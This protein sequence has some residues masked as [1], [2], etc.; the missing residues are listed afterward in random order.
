MLCP[1]AQAAFHLWSIREIY[2]DA[3]GSLQ[4]V[5]MVDNSGGQNFV[6]SQQISVANVGATQT[7]N[8]T[9]PSGNLPGSTLG[10]TLLL[11]TAGLAAAG[12]PTPDYI[13]PNNFLFSAGGT[14]NFWGTS[15]NSPLTYSALPTDGSHSRIT[16]GGSGDAINSPQNFAGATGTIVVPEP[17]TW[18]LLGTGATTLGFFLRR[19]DRQ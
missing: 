8:F 9:L 19:R 16:L 1:S 2:T 6:G 10:H 11:G 13:I 4:F 18:A 15:G 3:S 14:I 7:H 5:E 17:T 12:G